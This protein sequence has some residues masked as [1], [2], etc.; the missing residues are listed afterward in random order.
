MDGDYGDGRHP[1]QVSFTGNL[2]EDLRRRD[3]TV[4]AMAYSPGRGLVDLFG[5]QEDLE[6]GVIRCVGDP[7]ERFGEDALRMLRAVRFSAQLGFWIQEDT[8]AAIRR[9]SPNLQKISQERIRTELMKL[10]L[11]PHPEKIREAAALGITAVVLPEYDA[12]IG[13]AQNTPYH[14]CDVA[15]HTVRVLTHTRRDPV[16]RLTALL[17]DMGKPACKST[18]A[19]GIDHFY[20]HDA[21]SGRMSEEILRRL[22]FDNATIRTVTRLVAAHGVR[23]EKTESAVRRAVSRMGAD[24]YP[25]Y[26]EFR[27]A[28]NLGKS[29]FAI[30]RSAP[31]TA[32]YRETYEKLMRERVPLAVR[33]LAVSGSDLLEAGVPAG[34]AVGAVLER[35]LEAVLENPERNNREEL[36]RIVSIIR[37]LPH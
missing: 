17:H 31:M 30:R 2:A 10:L 23:C 16:M 28:D 37:E 12:M 36:L 27:D 1:D 21:V 8:A 25:L 22:R 7:K 3:F 5:G 9:L 6:R 13:V 33:D 18:G 14:C 11:S 32:Y 26:L 29:A 15:E 19:D 34:R 24:L 20:G 35:L 4:N